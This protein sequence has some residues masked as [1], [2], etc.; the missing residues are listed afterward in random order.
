MLTIGDKTLTS[1]LLLGTAQYPSLEELQH[2]VTASGTEILTVS[3]RRQAAA[4]EKSET[5]WHYI[6]NLGCHILPNTAGCHQAQEAVTIANMSREI[7]QTNWIKLE[8]IG[9]DYNL[10]P[11]PIELLTA[12]KLL[13]QDGFDVFAYCT[14][15]LVLCKRLLA[16]GVKVLMPWGSPIGSGKGLVNPYGLQILRERISDAI[17]FVDAGIGLPS[18]AAQAMEMGYDGVLL[19]S[20]VAYADS[21]RLMAE[22]FKYSVM[23][24]RLAFEAGKMPVREFAKPSTP[25]IDQPFWSEN[26]G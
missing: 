6:K 23:S 17:L 2:A 8:V 7:F 3:L 20:A 18:H 26:L 22:A 10:Q 21:P 9:D 24:G 14:E 1:R 11:D 16:C 25:T 12:A 4:Q 5:F 15:D 19:N 13:A